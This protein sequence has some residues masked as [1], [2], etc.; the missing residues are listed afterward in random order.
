[1]D[2]HKSKKLFL[3]IILALRPTVCE[4]AWRHFVKIVN[5]TIVY[6]SN[7]LITAWDAWSHDPYELLFV[8]PE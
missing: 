3:Q 5:C 4:E 7:L 2:K 1:M 6:L 8:A